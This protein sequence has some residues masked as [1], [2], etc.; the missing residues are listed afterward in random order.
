MT[1]RL[2]PTLLDL[3]QT[4]YRSRNPTRRWLH[5]VR[6]EWVLDALGRYGCAPE[7]RALEVGPGCGIYLPELSRYFREVVASDI[8]ATFLDQARQ[9]GQRHANLRPVVDDIRAS[10]LPGGSFDLILCSEVIEHLSDSRAALAGMARL[11]RPGGVLL[12]TTPQ[13]YSPLELLGRIAFHPRILPLV[14]QLYRE[15]VLPT[16]H[17]NVLTVRQCATQLRDAGFILKERHCCG[18]YLPGV[19]EF[20]GAAGMALE[21]RLESWLRRTPAE[22]L[23]WTQCHVAIKPA[24]RSMTRTNVM[25]K[26]GAASHVGTTAE[27]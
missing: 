17:V 13:R 2:P 20:C 16:G 27:S 15:P 4:L 1:S 10:R 14:R 9:L 12:L 21:Q 19:A 18:L 25:A 3:Q 8:E 22:A 23:L 6:R 5:N 11:L 26:K 24:S 7:G